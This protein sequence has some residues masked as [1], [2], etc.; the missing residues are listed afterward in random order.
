MTWKKQ[1]KTLIIDKY[2]DKKDVNLRRKFTTNNIN[3]YIRT[4]KY[5]YSWYGIVFDSR[6]LVLIS[7]FDFG[8]IVVIFVV[9]N[10]SFVHVGYKKK[11]ILAL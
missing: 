8:K 1:S 2:V 9:D 6:S 10:S 3:L 11:Y 4:Y 7:S 5:L